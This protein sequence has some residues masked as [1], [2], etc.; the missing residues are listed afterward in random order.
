MRTVGEIIERIKVERQNDIL[1]LSIGDLI[2]VLT[3]EEAEKIRA[4]DITK[5]DW[6]VV[7]SR[8]PGKVKER[9]VDYLPFAIEKVLD[10]RGISADRSVSH[11]RN[12]VWLIGDEE[13]LKFV[14]NHSNYPQYGAPVLKYLADRYGFNYKNILNKKELNMFLNMSKGLPC[15]VGC[16][17]GCGK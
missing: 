2:G 8:E 5:D 1:G 9:L 4:E 11:M 6:G 12:Y 10:H 3:F 7:L 15:E 14:E 17:M 16:D 13:A